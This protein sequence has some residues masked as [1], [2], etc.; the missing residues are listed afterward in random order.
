MGRRQLIHVRNVR[1]RDLRGAE[2]F[3]TAARVAEHLPVGNRGPAR[4]AV[5]VCGAID[6]L[7]Q[8]AADRFVETE[9][10]ILGGGQGAGRRHGFR[11]RGQGEQRPRA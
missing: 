4:G 8:V 7:G 10:A 1:E 6:E 3:A 5:L 11:D 9:E 2:I